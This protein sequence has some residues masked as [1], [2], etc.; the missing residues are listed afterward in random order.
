MNASPPRTETGLSRRRF[1]KATALAVGGATFGVPVL[2]RGR[3]LN[4]KLDIAVIGAGGKGASDTDC[5]AGENI[6]ALC[7]ADQ[8]N[9]AKQIDKY[10]RARFY[11][12]FRKIQ[13]TNK[14]KPEHLIRELSTV[15]II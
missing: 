11:R 4:G 10:P 14:L 13:Y 3:N 7:D 2:L 6:V 5:C 15:M 9:C 8:S 12:D 1:I